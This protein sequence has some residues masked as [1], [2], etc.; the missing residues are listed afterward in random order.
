MLMRIFFNVIIILLV[1][2]NIIA[3]A[4]EPVRG[5][6]GMVVSAH[7][8]A[9]EVGVN[10]L[11]SGGNAVDAAVAVG[12]AL[13][14]VHPSAGN[15]GGGGFMVIHQK[16]GTQTTF[17][18]REKAPASTHKNIYLDE[19]GKY[20]P[21]LSTQGWSASGVPG[22][23]AGMLAALNKYG[24]MS[25]EE[26]IEP[27]IQLAE[28]GFIMDYRMV[29]FVN[30]YNK[31]FNQY[32]SSKKIF[33]KNGEKFNEGDKLT[34]KDL[35][36]T[37]KRI[38]GRGREGFY[39][40]QTAELIAEQAKENGGYISLEDLKNYYPVE[41]EPVKGNYRGYEIVSMAPPSSGGIA[42][43]QTLNILENFDIKKN[44]WGSSNFVHRF[45]EALKYVYADRSEHL[46]DE[47]FYPVPKKWL[48]SKE[49][50]E[51]IF[52]GIIEEAVASEKIKPGIDPNLKKESLETTHYSVID[53]FGNAVSVTTT[54]NSTFGNKIVVEGAGFLMNNEMDDFS[55]KPGEPNQFGL[56]G[57]EANSIQPGKRMLSSMT[58]TIVLKN[59]NPFII[60]GSPGGS[61][62]I[63]TVIQVVL[64][65]IDF[66]MDI[67][68]AI[69]MPRIHHQWYPD[70]IYYEKFVLNNDAINAL[71]KRG[72]KFGKITKIGRAQGILIDNEN[73]IFWGAADPRS[74]GKAIGY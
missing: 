39:E 47:D 3:E 45:V 37:L 63:T 22:S 29:D 10:I 44:D 24:T 30:A 57:S 49:Y 17:D 72:H 56:L 42:L 16:D 46:G 4:P 9:S 7:S 27:A 50:A 13:A 2:T 5:K 21:K 8:L 48:T 26:I 43:I 52:E 71:N 59:G 34:Q 20:D 23:V 54:I 74:Y 68:T 1:F 32:S 40:G 14:V 60:I 69:N 65:V 61:R 55:A 12:F 11:K 19:N 36:E 58:P 53:K 73:K 70:E 38:K 35:A 18:Y 6:N 51:E 41:R 66:E 64:N 25:I 67:Q 62:I 33:T 15:L 31:R 28:R